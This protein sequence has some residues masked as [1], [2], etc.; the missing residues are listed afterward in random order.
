ML[1]SVASAQSEPEAQM[2]CA[3]LSEAG[4][5]AVA[6]RNIGADNPE[7]GVAGARDV[8]VDEELAAR[9]RELLAV[10]Q[11]SDDELAQLSEQAGREATEAP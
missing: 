9:A 8:Y 3:R 10:P 4:I 7:F 6:K 2:I 1:V 11:F 5:R